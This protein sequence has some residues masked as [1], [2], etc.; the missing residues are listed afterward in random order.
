[1]IAWAARAAW[2]MGGKS[3]GERSASAPTVL[4]E[5]L[6][7]GLPTV[8]PVPPSSASD[9][10]KSL[11]PV[12]HALNHNLDASEVTH[13]LLPLVLTRGA[14]APLQCVPRRW[15]M[16]RTRPHHLRRGGRFSATAHCDSPTPIWQVELDAARAAFASWRKH[17]WLDPRSNEL[18]PKDGHSWTIEQYGL[19]GFSGMYAK[20]RALCRPPKRRPSPLV[21]QSADSHRSSAKAPTLTAR[22][23]KRRPP[24]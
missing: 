24:A 22:L 16:L 23:P 18:K 6:L 20:K 14:F 15:L 13:R 2:G 12:L 3:Q 8:L 5:A 21:C 19:P 11:H 10:R 1:M 9:M 17:E 4:A 7:A